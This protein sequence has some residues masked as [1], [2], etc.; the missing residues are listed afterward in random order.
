MDLIL[1]AIIT[2]VIGSVLQAA[3]L[4][5]QAKRLLREYVELAERTARHLQGESD[6]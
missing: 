2:S 4:K 1:L 3:T 5:A 6:G